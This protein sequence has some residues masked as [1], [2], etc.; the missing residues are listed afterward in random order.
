MGMQE[1]MQKPIAYCLY[2]R[3]SS[4]SEERQALSI[5]SQISEMKKIAERDGLLV[6]DIRR[7]SH[8]AK[9]RGMRPV[10]NKIIDDIRTGKFTGI[11]TWAPD[12]LSRNAGDLGIIVDLMD[13]KRLLEIRTFGQAFADSPNDKFLLMIL[14]SQA[15]LE[16]D[17][18]SVNVKRGMRSRVQM[19]LW[20][21]V[22]PLGYLN[23]YRT[24]KRCEVILDEQRAPIIKQV[25]M[26]V[27]N[28]H[29]STRKIYL[30]LDKEMGFRTKGNK[31]LT[32]SGVQRML[33]NPF[34]YGKFEYP[35][36]SGKWYDGKHVPIV[37][38][39]LFDKAKK[40]LQRDQIVR[41]NKEFSFVRLFSCGLCGSGIGAEEKLKP[42]KDG[43]IAKYCYYGCTRARDRFCKNQYIREDVLIEQLIE[44]F[45]KADIDELGV[46]QKFEQEAV[47]FGKFRKFLLGQPTELS[48]DEVNL[49]LKVYVVYVLRD[50][51]ISE[52]RELLGHLRSRL[53]LKNKQ[54]TLLDPSDPMIR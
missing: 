28:E 14:G 52:K 38:K 7:E 25:F 40:H 29:L 21:G 45:D 36:G 22:A 20:P 33:T 1:K 24:D 49:N 8:S 13:Q 51:S 3:K 31:V 44:I 35:R 19:G 9:D 17:N 10:F 27:A 34:Y 32:L 46:G 54:I 48:I 30:W 39:Q 42:L 37:T 26:K 50:G 6:A 23:Q 11:L 12:R 4:E 5:E 41:R 43:T 18:R 53:Q 2:A 47:R 15:K 16:N